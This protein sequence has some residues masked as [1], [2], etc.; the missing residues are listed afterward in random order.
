MHWLDHETFGVAASLIPWN[1]VS[2]E[3]RADRAE[4]R[5]LKKGSPSRGPAPEEQRA[6]LRITLAELE[7]Q[8]VAQG[9]STDEQAGGRPLSPTSLVGGSKSDV[10]FLD[11]SVYFV[12][13]WL[14][15]GLKVVP[16]LLPLKQQQAG[17]EPAPFPHVLS[18]LARMRAYLAARRT[19]LPKA[20]KLD[21]TAAAQHIAQRGAPAAEHL[22]H[23][24]WLGA[25]R[26]D[27]FDAADPLVRAGGL[28][29][30]Q[31][32]DVVPTDTGRVV[33]GGL[34][35]RDAG[36]RGGLATNNTTVSS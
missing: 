12:L 19:A 8:M 32:V 35:G 26:Q 29:A 4:F 14:Q 34:A 18:Y 13:D 27:I 2:D 24:A 23:H 31:E 25:P 9:M 11:I 36:L 5:G 1:M 21:P 7:A 16:D 3:F 17:D 10:Q 33:R 28:Y 22:R 20:A 15:T 6:K 30:G